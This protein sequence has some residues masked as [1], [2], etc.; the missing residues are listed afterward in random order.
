MVRNVRLAYGLKDTHSR[1]RDRGLLTLDEMAAA[2]GVSTSTVKAWRRHGLLRAHAYNDKDQYLYEP[3]GED[4]P[5][6]GKWRRRNTR[7]EGRRCSMKH[8]P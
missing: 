7:N 2:L 1:L 4:A 6:K 8:R 5:V 3:P